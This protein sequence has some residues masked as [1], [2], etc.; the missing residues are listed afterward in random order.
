[1]NSGDR[2]P[3]RAK[4]TSP[5]RE[6]LATPREVG[7]RW[8]SLFHPRGSIF[9][10]ADAFRLRRRWG[11]TLIELCRNRNTAGQPRGASCS[12]TCRALAD[13][14]EAGS[15]RR[16]E[17]LRQIPSTSTFDPR[18]SSCVNRSP[19]PRLGQQQTAARSSRAYRGL[20]PSSSPRSACASTAKAPRASPSARDVSDNSANLSLFLFSFVYA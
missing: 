11:G 19:S 9:R 1:V 10:L 7:D 5:F 17:A 20:P 18:S 15:P 13:V 4:V 14:A 12:L 16:R 3:Q 6:G 2:Y 8:R